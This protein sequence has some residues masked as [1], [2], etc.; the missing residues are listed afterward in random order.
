MQ[1]QDPREPLTIPVP[2]LQ[3]LEP[4]TIT[5]ETSRFCPISLGDWLN[6]CQ[7]AGV[8]AVPALQMATI[9]RADYFQWDTPGQH[10]ERLQEVFRQVHESIMPR[11]MLRYDC[12]A[13]I[14]TKM[15]LS[16]G[17]P[18]WHPDMALM[19]FDDPRLV[20]IISEYPREAI[21]VWQRPW[22]DAEILEHYPVEYRVYV[23]NGQIQGI[24]NYYPQRPIAL[25]QNH[26]NQV[27]QHTELLI[28]HAQTP[29]L[30][31]NGMLRSA[32]DAKEDPDGVHFTADYILPEGGNHL[33]F[34]EGGPPHE[35]G[36]HPCCFPAD[37]INGIALE[38]T[39]DTP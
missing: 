11:H 7:K 23:R 27:T 31:N 15:R 14:E 12:C 38:L 19:I 36:A 6:L 26:I 16:L 35:L 39:P 37:A 29:F 9:N 4:I 24:S 25:N 3:A 1:K 2:E 32:F 21:P 5:D 33:L 20:D 8:P 13:P 28:Q 22:L 18:E 34:L 10:H 17:E 30:W